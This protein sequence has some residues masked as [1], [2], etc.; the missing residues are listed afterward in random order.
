[1]NKLKMFAFIMLMTSATSTLAA[2][3][4]AALIAATPGAA[5]GVATVPITGGAAGVI[6]SFAAAGTLGVVGA[7]A[8]IALMAVLV[9]Y[10]DE[11]KKGSESS[12]STSVTTKG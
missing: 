10:T 12:T 11:S 3:E 4:T 8:G 2:P 5:A 1:M 7:T 9:V 6:G